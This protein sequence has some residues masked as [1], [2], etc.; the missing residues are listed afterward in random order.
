MTTVADDKARLVAILSSLTDGVVLTDAGGNVVIVNPA[1]E[2]LFAFDGARLTGRPLIEAIQDHE[3]DK[4]VRECLKTSVA[5]TAQLDSV[6]GRFLR[7]IA[8]PIRIGTERGALVLFQDLTEVRSLQ[9]MRREF[10]GNVSHELRTPL[11][12]MKAIVETLRDGAVQDKTVAADF[13]NRLDIEV[14][15][16]T[17]MVA[18]LIELSRIETGGIELRL[19][20]VDLR[21]TVAEVVARLGPLAER[22]LV[23]LS[24]R[25]PADLPAALADR[26]RIRQ[27]IINIVHNAI[28]FTAP[29]GQVTVSARQVDATIVTEVSD[30][31]IGISA[32]DL[33]HVFERFFKADRSRATGGTGLGLAIARHTVQAHRGDIWVT[34]ELGKGST[35]SFSLPLAPSGP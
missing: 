22:L 28:K 19:E 3:V 10:V 26:D 27:V 34:S 14:D 7:T 21:E 11:A 23:T 24:T 2:K 16:M 13:L 20:P 30:T 35:F 33:P 5:Q 25:R 15:G 32:D 1:A 29:G 4:V 6:T 31:G 8:V 18:G 12:G 9:T 17:Q